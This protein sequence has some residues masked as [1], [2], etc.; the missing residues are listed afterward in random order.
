MQKEP[1]FADQPWQEKPLGLRPGQLARL[2]A[3]VAKA[4][5]WDWAA[6]AAVGLTYSLC[7]VRLSSEKHGLCLPEDAGASTECVM[8]FKKKWFVY[9]SLPFWMPGASVALSFRG[10]FRLRPVPVDRMLF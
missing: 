2:R 4:W 1:E 7:R 6:Q 3:P 9:L 8:S 5:D 10:E